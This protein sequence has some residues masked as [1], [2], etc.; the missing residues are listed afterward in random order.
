MIKKKEKQP[1][2]YTKELPE[3]VFGLT[4]PDIFTILP[5]IKR[6]KKKNIKKK[7]RKKVKEIHRVMPDLEIDFSK[8][9]PKAAK[10]LK[11]DNVVTIPVDLLKAINKETENGTKELSDLM[12]LHILPQILAYDASSNYV[13]AVLRDGLNIEVDIDRATLE[14]VKEISRL[15]VINHFISKSTLPDSLKTRFLESF[16]DKTTS[17]CSDKILKVERGDMMSETIRQLQGV[18]VKRSE[19]KRPKIEDGNERVIQEPEQKG[20]SAVRRSRKV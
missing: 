20:R 10:G 3:G 13:K 19:G 14:V 18:L 17:V 9:I 4:D 1:L 7:V 5:K 2:G 11:L 6:E 12:L 8:R 16:I 15:G